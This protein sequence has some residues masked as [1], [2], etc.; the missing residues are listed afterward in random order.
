VLFFVEAIRQAVE[1]E[2]RRKLTGN[3]NASKEKTMCQL[4]DTSFKQPERAEQKIA[5][6]FNTNRTYVN[7]AANCPY[8]S[9]WDQAHQ[10]CI[11]Y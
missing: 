10:I 5:Q 1:V 11:K 4:I 7:E 8:L 6:T 2:K 9:K 3:E